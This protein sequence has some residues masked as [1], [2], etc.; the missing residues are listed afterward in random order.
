MQ[1]FLIRHGKTQGNL[2]GRY[3]GSTDEPLCPLGAGELLGRTAPPVERLYSSPMRRC[4]Q[5]AQLLYPRLAP[6]PLDGLRE[7]DFGD[8]EYRTYEQLQD[9]PAYRAWI[10]SGGRQAPPG[11]E[12]PPPLPGLLFA[13]VGK[14][15]EGRRGAGGVFNP[16]RRHDG[17][18]GNVGR[19]APALLP[20]AGKKW[21][22]LGCPGGLESG[23]GPAG[24]PKQLQK[25]GVRKRDEDIVGGRFGLPFGSR[26][27]GPA[28]DAPSGPLDG[29]LDRLV[30][31][32]AAPP[33]PGYP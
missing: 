14:L 20:L 8:F 32:G 26:A 13:G 23:G 21:R 6:I 2:E 25:M 30:G 18:S 11:G 5:S 12:T 19:P 4:L 16:R 15:P 9:C 17:P 31:A 10:A 33:F 7:S 1:V 3:V 24:A 22:R 28:L 29:A 27:G